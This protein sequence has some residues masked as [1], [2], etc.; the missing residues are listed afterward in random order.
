[1]KR[2]TVKSILGGMT[3]QVPRQEAVNRLA[4]YEDTGLT[5]EEVRAMNELFEYI[6]ED[7]QAL[8]KAVK[9]FQWLKNLINAEK[10]GRLI[11]LPCKV[12]EGQYDGATLH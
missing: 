1:M 8:P 10:D 7:C 12:G 9:R 4:A 5:P 3:I 2:L 11:V 6:N